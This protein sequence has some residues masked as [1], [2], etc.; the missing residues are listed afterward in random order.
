H[1]TSK[2]STNDLKMALAV[3]PGGNW[4]NIPLS[5]ESQRLENIRKSYAAGEG[6]RSTYYGRL[7]AEYPAYTINTYFKRPGNGCH[8]HYD[9]DGGQ[10]RVLSE[11]EA[12]RIQ[13]FPDRF[14][15]CGP[16]TAILKQIGN[17]VPP[18]LGYQVARAIPQ[19]GYF[20]DLFSGAGGLSLGF[21]WAGWRPIVAND[22]ESPFLDTYR[23]NVHDSAICGDIRRSDVFNAIVRQVK[24]AKIPRG[25]PL[26]VLGG[27]PCQGF[28]TA[29][30][31]RSMED[32]RNQLFYEYKRM[33]VALGVDGFVFENVTG[34][35]N[36]DGGAVF[37]LV[38]RE[39]GACAKSLEAWRMQA[40]NYGVPQRRTRIVLVGHSLAKNAVTPPEPLTSMATEPSLFGQLARVISVEEAIGD[41]PPLVPGEDGSQKNYQHPPCSPYQA[42][43]RGQIT[44]DR[45][46]E[47][48]AKAVKA[49]DSLF[50]DVTV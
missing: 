7:R 34:L 8:L 3:P 41:L 17:A 9:F 46:L 37:E 16:H 23:H 12:A 15:F 22:I 40:E 36:M 39:L 43:M 49:Q 13:S 29:G 14:V 30:K 31:R 33:L 45:Y 18:L 24:D 19:K 47:Q 25:M 11:R 28:S 44:P 50:A 4:K 1:Y 6:S 10:H 32:H 38:K 21:K 48:L 2:L 20:V 5:V 42:L 27:P 26:F 35:L